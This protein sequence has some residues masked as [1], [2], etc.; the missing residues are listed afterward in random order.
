MRRE[1]AESAEVREK[2]GGRGGE[3]E[4]AAAAEVPEERGSGAGSTG[5]SLGSPR[6]RGES[7]RNQG[8]ESADAE[9]PSSAPGIRPGRPRA[10][11][12]AGGRLRL[13]KQGCAKR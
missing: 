1:G 7:G 3:G 10:R 2:R 6:V 8:R 5:A 9:K 11:R 4:G 13:R 12:L